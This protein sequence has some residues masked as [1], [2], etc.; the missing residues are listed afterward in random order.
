LKSVSLFIAFCCAVVFAGPPEGDFA[1]TC[2]V[3]EPAL[4][5]PLKSFEVPWF[6][7]NLD[8]P[9]QERYKEIASHYHKEMAEVIQ[10]IKDML[11]LLGDLPF[12]M[13]VKLMGYAEDEL[14]PMPYKLEIQ[15]IAEASGIPVA[16]LAL[17][18]IYYELSR[19]CT[20]IVAQTP[21]GQLF[22]AR[23][24]DFGQLFIWDNS[25]RSWKLTEKLKKVTIN[26][27]FI[28][29]GQI[30]FK[31]TT[32]AGHVG[33]ITGM[34]PQA[35]SI[36][37]NAKV[38][39]DITNVISWFSGGQKDVHFVM[40]VERE[41]FEKCSTFQEARTYLS[42]VNQLAGCY[43]ILG[44]AKQDE[45]VII[46]RNE[47]SVMTE[48]WLDH[49]NPDSWYVL[50]TN[51]DPDQKPIFLDDRITPGNNCMKKLTQAGV[52]PAGLYQVL[53]SKTNLNKTTVHTVIMS[54]ATGLYQTFIQYCPDPCWFL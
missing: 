29:N 13:L 38:L 48:V 9:P 21:E 1:P 4:Y 49:T 36:S 34:R 7:V 31:G 22:H 25:T 23:N 27:N 40:W 39:P 45:G 16:E 47:T 19:F 28:K 15:G 26:I 37:M 54:V 52:S 10:V 2:H 12:E 24:L 41:V 44:G 17:M 33:I 3:G 8:A 46:V 14:I 35:F 50:Q 42:S 51:Y 18:N 53:A 43:Y 6:N 32:M 30:L 5:D 11:S 20:S